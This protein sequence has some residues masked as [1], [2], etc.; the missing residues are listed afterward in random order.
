MASV[1][2]ASIFMKE[3]QLLI[4]KM[5]KKCKNSKNNLLFPDINI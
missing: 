2:L 5:Q 1:M 4:D 3:K